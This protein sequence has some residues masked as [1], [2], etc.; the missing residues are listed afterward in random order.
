MA[1]KPS[2]SMAALALALILAPLCA[3]GP[4]RVG[5]AQLERLNFISRASPDEAEAGPSRLGLA[6]APKFA[7]SRRARRPELM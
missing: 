1:G 3:G 4:A 7:R 5:A 6:P 2:R